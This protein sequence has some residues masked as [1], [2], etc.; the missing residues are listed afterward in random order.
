MLTTLITVT[1]IVR[2][3]IVPALSLV[4]AFFKLD[5]PEIPNA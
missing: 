3:R 1:V 2:K 5:P 4:L